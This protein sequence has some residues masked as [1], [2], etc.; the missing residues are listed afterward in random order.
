MAAI[1]RHDGCVELQQLRY[2]LAVAETRNFTRAAE[3]CHV[4]QS[5]LSHQVKA[6][7]SEL[8][9]RLFARSSRRVELTA[10]GEA[11][12]P[13]AR[14]TLEA[15]E[16]AASDALAATGVVQGVLRIGAI[17]TVTAI[18]LP[19]LIAEV[20]AAHRDV[21]IEVRAGGSGEFVTAIAAGDLD[22]AVLGFASSVTPN[23]VASLQLSRERLVAVLAPGHPLAVRRRVVL[24]DLADDVF[25]D[26]E[27][28]GPGRAQS[29]SA[30]AE[31]GLER[32]VAFEAADTRLMLDLVA[33]G[34]A[35]ALLPAGAVPARDDVTTVRVADGPERIEHLAWSRFNPTPAALAFVELARAATWQPDPTAADTQ[36]VTIASVA[37]TL[38]AHPEPPMHATS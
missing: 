27:A 26:F 6:L 36:P 8:G 25:V 4:V 31:A 1:V 13:S 18:D 37:P 28:G 24:A 7:E 34:L 20:R 22:V 9:V 19:A 15:A 38:P 30:F 12:L 17:P 3:Q 16:R 14:A 32:D 21:R 23:G 10:A 11:F 5:A 29:D 33:A 35:I 2:V